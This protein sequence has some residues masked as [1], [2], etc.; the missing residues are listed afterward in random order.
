MSGLRSFYEEASGEISKHKNNPSS[1]SPCSAVLD[2]ETYLLYTSKSNRAGNTTRIQTL[3]VPTFIF[4][5]RAIKEN[6]GEIEMAI[7][8]YRTFLLPAILIW[9][10]QTYCVYG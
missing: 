1:V 10:L 2:L 5:L 7:L 3:A 8:Q 9:S 6:P 4:L